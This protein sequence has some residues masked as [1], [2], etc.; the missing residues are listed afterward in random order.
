MNYGRSQNQKIDR[1]FLFRRVK[2]AKVYTEETGSERSIQIRCQN[3]DLCIYK[4]VILFLLF[5]H[6]VICA[7]S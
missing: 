5:L 2:Y 3:S 1:N 6:M 4:I 7:T